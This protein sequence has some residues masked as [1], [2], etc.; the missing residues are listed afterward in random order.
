MVVS[1]FLK[2]GKTRHGNFIHAA[3]EQTLPTQKK[4][5]AKTTPRHA[6]SSKSFAKDEEQ[7]LAE[8]VMIGP[9]NARYRGSSLTVVSGTQLEPI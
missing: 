6:V 9:I 5:L 8:V 3:G 2:C 7:N 4:F 1:K